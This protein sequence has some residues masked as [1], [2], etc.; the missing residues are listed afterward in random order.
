LLSCLKSEVEQ[1]RRAVEL[2][3]ETAVR[4]VLGDFPLRLKLSW[5]D[6]KFVDEKGQ[7]VW[8][9]ISAALVALHRA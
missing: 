8:D 4:Q 3:R 1:L 9:L 5:F 7:E 6:D 2:A